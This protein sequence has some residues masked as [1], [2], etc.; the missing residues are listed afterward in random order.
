[1][2]K[3]INVLVA[4]NDVKDVQNQASLRLWIMIEGILENSSVSKKQENQCKR[5][6]MLQKLWKCEVKA[7]LCWNLVIL[8]PLS[9]YVKSNLGKFKP[10]K[11][12]IFGSFR[13]SEL[14]HLVNLGLESCSNSLKSKFRISKIAKNDIL[15]SLHLPK[16]D[17][18]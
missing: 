10:S 5:I 17:F 14:W 18:T 9:F 16:L 4:R 3:S 6:T 7:W 13:D 8:L 11:N 2:L 15:D 12:V 1:M